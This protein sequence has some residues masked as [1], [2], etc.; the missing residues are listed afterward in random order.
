[1][2]TPSLVPLEGDLVG[3]HM[4]R[5]PVMVAES[6]GMGVALAVDIE[7][8]EKSG[9]VP[10]GLGLLRRADDRV[11]LIV[12]LH[13]QEVR[14]HVAHTGRAATGEVRA[15]TISH[16]YYLGL[17]P[18]PRPGAA[19]AAARKKIWASGR[20]D[21]VGR[22]LDQSCHEYA[23]QVYPAALDRLWAG[24]V[25]DG[26]RVGAITANRSYAGDVWFSCWFN[27]M[28]SSYGLYHYGMVL[29]RQEW[30]ERARATRA[31]VL[32][33]PSVG[34][35]FPTVF[36]FGENRW[37]ESHH[38]GGGPGVFHLMDMSWTMYQLLRWHRELEPDAESISRARSYARALV[39]L[40]RSDGG[41]PAYVDRD[42][43]PVTVVDRAA[44]LRDLDGG[45]GDPYVPHMIETRWG[46]AR[47]VDSAEDAASL[48]FL[49]TL[50]RLLPAGDGAREGVLGAARG[51]ARYLGERVVPSARWTDF[52]VYFSCSPK[53]LDFYDHRSG[54]WPQNTLCM[55]HG[56][57]GFLELFEVTGE[58]GY[59]E[60]AGRAMDRLCLYQ[61]VW[62]PRGWGSTPSAATA[63]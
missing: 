28:R 18:N 7:V 19:L 54:Q 48:L 16:R 44:L 60:L 15:R 39:G 29:S 12:G 4:L 34:G 57:A 59:L 26:R 31:L 40:Q 51:V 53:S 42:G 56:A 45:G 49:A 63:L 8:L 32:S 10:A 22:P 37:V 47:F 46:E 17:F 38:Q 6:V 23:L 58:V 62:A 3:R 41:L 13:A 9:A 35:L 25:L 30:V 43:A 27:P 36:R 14:G 20:G 55:Q 21:Q 33:A 2:F 24:T 61:Q 1:M 5:A 50:A 52:E 11:E